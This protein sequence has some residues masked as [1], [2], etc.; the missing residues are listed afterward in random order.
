M[1]RPQRRIFAVFAVV[2]LVIVALELVNA[3]G[4]GDEFGYLTVGVVLIMLLGVYHSFKRN[5]RGE[6]GAE[7][8]A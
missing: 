4:Q 7:P 2:A 6:G 3:L 1:R 8:N 5:M